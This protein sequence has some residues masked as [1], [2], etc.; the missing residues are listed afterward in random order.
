MRLQPI[1]HYGQ[2]GLK[3]LVTVEVQLVSDHN[4]QSTA[5]SL[6]IRSLPRQKF[7]PSRYRP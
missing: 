6:E 2:Q 1:Q 7:F 4:H 5:V 3:M